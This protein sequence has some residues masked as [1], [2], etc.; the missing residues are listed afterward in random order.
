MIM[1]DSVFWM[2]FVD[3]GRAPT[4]KHGNLIDAMDE[5]RRL[6]IKEGSTVHVL[7]AVGQYSLAEPIWTFTPL[8]TE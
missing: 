6:S 4:K 3:S 5:A 8:S 1:S 2:V 7:Q